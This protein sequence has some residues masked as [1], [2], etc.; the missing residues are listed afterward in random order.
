MHHS[1]LAG[2]ITI[3]S[4]P[5]A[6][7]QHIEWGL[8]SLLGVPQHFTWRDQPLAAG[9]IRTTLEYRGEVGL[10]SKFKSLATMVA[11]TLGLHQSLESIEQLSMQVDRF[12]LLR[13]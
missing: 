12:L 9:T 3:H 4:A 1:S 10:A 6:L 13:T 2:L 5:T 7:R 11:N 8:N